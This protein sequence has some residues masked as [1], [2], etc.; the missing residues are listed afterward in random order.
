MIAH[1]RAALIVMSAVVGL[2]ACASAAAEQLLYSE[3]D[4]RLTR[5]EAQFARPIGVEKANYES[6]ITIPS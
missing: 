3:L 2:H 4:A 5:I 6:D 1:L